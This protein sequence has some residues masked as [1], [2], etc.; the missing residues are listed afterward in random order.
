MALAGGDTHADSSD[1]RA[2]GLSAFPTQGLEL[3]LRV[4]TLPEFD[5]ESADRVRARRR[6]SPSGPDVHQ[7]AEEERR[8]GP[9]PT[10]GLWAN[11]SSNSCS[12][13]SGSRLARRTRTGRPPRFHGRSARPVIIGRSQPPP[14]S[15][16]VIAPRCSTARP[17]VA[18]TCPKNSVSFR[19]TLSVKARTPGA[20][21]NSSSVME[22]TRS[23]FN[24]W[25]SVPVR[26]NCSFRRRTPVRYR[27]VSTRSLNPRS[28]PRCA[29]SSNSFT[30]QES[31]ES[32]AIRMAVPHG[33]TG[34]AIRWSPFWTTQN[35]EKSVVPAP[36]PPP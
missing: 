7:V 24:S 35:I 2:P 33:S 17:Q 26:N 28:A 29:R 11:A 27:S 9:P 30:K 23:S 21:R 1:G 36:T 6:S 3:A 19:T 25:V 31:R 8:Q 15:T 5:I 4:T 20:L 13:I 10:A 12:T 22:T 14:V 32:P 18:S 34:T 16:I